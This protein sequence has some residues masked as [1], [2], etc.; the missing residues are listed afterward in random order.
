MNLDLNFVVAM[1]SSLEEERG[2]H[3]GQ[4]QSRKK[5]FCP[6]QVMNIL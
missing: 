5:V 2:R 6:P 4:G 3:R 1:N